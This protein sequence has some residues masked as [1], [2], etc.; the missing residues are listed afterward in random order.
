[1]I[2]ENRVQFMEG[3][4]IGGKEWVSPIPCR[5][6]GGSREVTVGPGCGHNG[7]CPCGGVEKECTHCA[8]TRGYEPCAECGEQ[9][10]TVQV[11]SAYFCAECRERRSRCSCGRPATH[12][13]EGEPVCGFCKSRLLAR[14]GGVR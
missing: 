11:G 4:R 3:G 12:M 8:E 7:H 1:M 2:Q 10:A 9:P 14:A 13:H 6:C 5:V